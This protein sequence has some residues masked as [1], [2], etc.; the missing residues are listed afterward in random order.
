MLK[1]VV[2][3][4]Y[5]RDWETCEVIFLYR[6]DNIKADSKGTNAAVW[7]WSLTNIPDAGAIAREYVGGFIKNY[8]IIICCVCVCWFQS[9]KKYQLGKSYGIKNINFFSYV[10]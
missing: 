7:R 5:I 8:T 2:Y 6:V 10:P 1:D 4:Q 9:S 3:V